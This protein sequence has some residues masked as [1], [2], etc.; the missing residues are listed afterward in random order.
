MGE[1]ALKS[2][3]DLKHCDSYLLEALMP[4]KMMTLS[5]TSI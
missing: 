4:S 3:H 1:L 5:V 2:H